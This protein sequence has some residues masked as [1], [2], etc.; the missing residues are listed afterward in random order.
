MN[1]VVDGYDIVKKAWANSR[2]ATRKIDCKQIRRITWQLSPRRGEPDL[3]TGESL[4][5]SLPVPWKGLGTLSAGPSFVTLIQ[6]VR[7][8]SLGDGCSFWLQA[9]VWAVAV[10]TLPRYCDRSPQKGQTRTQSLL[11]TLYCNCTPT[12]DGRSQH[13]RDKGW[14]QQHFPLTDGSNVLQVHSVKL[15]TVAFYAW[16]TTKTFEQGRKVVHTGVG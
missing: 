9:I 6:H 11:E 4:F 7:H 16:L 2:W 14:Q 13:R 1:R 10:R 8:F 15:N 5:I 3:K 12:T